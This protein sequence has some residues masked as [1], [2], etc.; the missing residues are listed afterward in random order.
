[1]SLDKPHIK[2]QI[3]KGVDLAAMDL[4]GLSDPYCIITI[5]NAP[6]KHRTVIKP[7]T[8]NPV[9]YHGAEF[10][11]NIELKRNEIEKLEEAI[12]ID[13]YDKDLVGSDDYMGQVIISG[14]KLVHGINDEWFDLK[15]RKGKEKK[16]KKVK[17]KILIEVKYLEKANLDENEIKELLHMTQLNE[18]D[19]KSLWE[20]FKK[21]GYGQEINNP[22]QLKK[23]LVTTMSG[24]IPW[25]E[26]LMRQTD[27]SGRNNLY[28]VKDQQFKNN[29]NKDPKM[30]QYIVDTIWRALDT[31]KSSSISFTELLIGLNSICSTDKIEKARFQFRVMDVDKSGYLD[32]E[33]L[34]RL[35]KFRSHA[36]RA[37][38]ELLFEGLRSDLSRAGIYG[39]KQDEIRDLVVEKLYFS[40]EIVNVSVDLC[41]KFADKDGDGKVSEDE[42]I[43]WATD[44]QQISEYID[45]FEKTMAFLIQK[46]QSNCQEELQS[47][48]VKSIRGF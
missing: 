26:L 25:I 28:E 2:I 45:Q 35:A 17:G 16:D 22:D 44:E 48:I 40:P 11:Q 21:E 14:S 36:M 39:S 15:P 33:E 23:I 1:M 18:K 30:Q 42:Y 9:W 8:L 7:K 41:L 43:M 47:A 32:K 12:I 3:K 20:A 29:V 37:H 19:V 34:I 13:M 6:T 38:Y 24:E 27:V 46:M 5:L 4:N 10:F 31:D